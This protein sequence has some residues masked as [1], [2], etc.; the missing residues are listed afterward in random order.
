MNAPETV[1]L[2]VSRVS[3]TVS[4]WPKSV[5]LSA[6]KR[7]CLGLAEQ[8][9]PG[10][11]NERLSDRGGRDRRLGFVATRGGEGGQHRRRGREA[12]RGDGVSAA[13]RGP[14]RRRR[15]QGRKLQGV[16]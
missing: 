9:T 2:T 13:A 11:V 14:A 15:P 10:R 8:P 12:D 5:H 3:L 4:A 7:Y 16:G 6:A 1:A